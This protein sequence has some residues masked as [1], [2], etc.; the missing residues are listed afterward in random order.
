MGIRTYVRK[1][2]QPYKTFVGHRFYMPLLCTY[3]SF[4]EKKFTPTE[5]VSNLP[6]P[7]LR[8]RVG[9]RPEASIFL[10]VGKRISEDIESALKQASFD[11]D[12]FEK[13]LDF[14]C[15]CGRTLIWFADRRPKFYGT[16]IDAEA[17]AWC[18]KN[19][20]FGN[21]NVNGPLPPLIYENGSFDFVCSISV[22]THLNEDFQFKWINELH[23]IIKTD[24]IL[25][26]TFHA[27]GSWKDLLPEDIIELQERGFIYR[28]RN[29]R[30]G[31]LPEWYQT[32]YHTK[33]YVVDAFSK[34]FRLL[35]YIEKGLKN[36]QDVAVFQKK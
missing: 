30:K 22:F 2:S 35:A 34:Q 29:D 10:S 16:D 8:Y 18:Q 27:K 6:P 19:L 11:L 13:V 32:A 31:V 3:L 24:G 28:V 4:T 1:K 23:R 26:A 21:F 9:Y 12:S 33:E 5:K 7:T 17:I 14:G 36:F 15:G 20:T 25:L